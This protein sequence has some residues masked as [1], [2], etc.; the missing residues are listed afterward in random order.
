MDC[1]CS[2]LTITIQYARL[3]YIVHFTYSVNS[4]TLQLQCKV[5]TVTIKHKYIASDAVISSATWWSLLGLD[6]PKL[7]TIIKLNIFHQILKKNY[8]VT[9]DFLF[10]IHWFYN[11]TDIYS[12][13]LFKMPFSMCCVRIGHIQTP[14]SM[15]RP[16]ST[17][18]T[19]NK[20]GWPEG[21]HLMGIF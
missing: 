4:V 9:M 12:S 3:L 2:L 7:A 17:G 8:L 5:Y 15:L 18:S 11:H 14:N 13:T 20:R 6:T 10:F 21:L 1:N 16:G 19:S